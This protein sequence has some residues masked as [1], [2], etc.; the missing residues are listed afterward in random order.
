MQV[1]LYTV[2]KRGNVSLL[3]NP[4]VVAPCC[5]TV[6]RDPSC[7]QSEWKKV[8]E[9]DNIC[10]NSS[11]DDGN[12]EFIVHIEDVHVLSSLCCDLPRAHSFQT[13]SASRMK[14]LLK[15]VKILEEEEKYMI[16]RVIAFTKKQVESRSSHKDT[17]VLLKVSELIIILLLHISDHRSQV[18]SR[19][20]HK[21]TQVLLKVS[22]LIIILL[23][24]ISDHRLKERLQEVLTLLTKEVEENLSSVLD[25]GHWSHLLGVMHQFLHLYYMVNNWTKSSHDANAKR[26]G[27]ELGKHLLCWTPETLL[28]CMLQLVK[29]RTTK[30]HSETQQEGSQSSNSSRTSLSQGSFS[31]ALNMEFEEFDEAGPSMTVKD[32]FQQFEADDKSTIMEGPTDANIILEN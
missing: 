7:A 24:H 1:A 14:T 13:N 18:E 31:R 4:V 12:S 26:N 29:T 3:K 2:G 15:E 19:S 25:T 17:Q 6:L 21:D 22:E 10:C 11:S 8:V 16:E 5:C 30:T 9:F 27:E 20:S 23:L 28:S 32:D